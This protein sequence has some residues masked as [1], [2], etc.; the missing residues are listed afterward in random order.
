MLAVSANLELF[1]GEE[2]VVDLE[3]RHSEYEVFLYKDLINNIYQVFYLPDAHKAT[4]EDFANFE[5]LGS[6]MVPSD[7]ELELAYKKCQALAYLYGK[8]NTL[9]Q[10]ILSNYSVLEKESWAQQEAEA[11]A[12]LA[13]QTP[14][15]DAL[16]A[17]RGC[18]RDELA[19]KIVANADAATNIGTGILAWQQSIE[20]QIKGMTLDDFAMIWDVISNRTL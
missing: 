6:I 11:R 13:V 3:H 17:V 5:F 10:S 7:P 18:S 19:K 20:T 4:D 12:L 2:K 1:Y 9:Y 8:V 15:I 16:C 14:L